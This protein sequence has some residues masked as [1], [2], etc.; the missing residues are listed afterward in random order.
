M[1]SWSPRIVLMRTCVHQYYLTHPS[2]AVPM[3]LQYQTVKPGTLQL[4]KS[5]Q[6]MPMFQRLQDMLRHRAAADVA[7]AD[8][9]Y[10]YHS[11]SP[12]VRLRAQA[13]QSSFNRVSWSRALTF[14]NPLSMIAAKTGEARDRSHRPMCPMFS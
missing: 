13:R 9:Q 12:L 11:S 7:V 8:K 2:R 6:S 14:W 5:L 1:K 4:L 10:F 3:L